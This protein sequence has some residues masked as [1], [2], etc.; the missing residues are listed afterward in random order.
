MEKEAI[1]KA[2][3]VNKIFKTKSGDVWVLKDVNLEINKGDFVVLFGP[4]GCGKSTLLHIC[5]GLESATSGSIEFAGVNMNNADDDQ[6]AEFRKANIGIIYQQ[7]NWI[8][9][10]NVMVNVAFP[11]MLKGYR[12]E[13]AYAKA[14]K[15]IDLVGMEKWV[16]YYPSELSSGQQQ[17]IGLARALVSEP[18]VIIAD[19]PTGN[20]DYKSSLDLISLFKKLA[21]EGT[22]IVMVT[23]NMDNL[24]YSNKI[25]QMFDGQILRTVNPQGYTDKQIHELLTEKLEVSV[26]QKPSQV[27]RTKFQPPKKDG[28]LKKIQHVSVYLVSVMKTLLLITIYMLDS[29]LFKIFKNKLIPHVFLTLYSKFTQRLYTLIEVLDKRQGNTIKFLDLA[30]LS[31]NNLISKKSR[32]LITIGGIAVGIS[33]TVLLISLGYGL[34]NLVITRVASLNELKQVDTIP[35]ISSNI[36]LTDES[37]NSISSFEGVKEVFPLVSIAGIVK[38]NNSQTETVIYAVKTNYL[39]NIEETLIAGEYFENKSEDVTFSDN[40]ILTDEN[41]VLTEEEETTNTKIVD[42]E[43]KDTS[44]VI[45]NSSMLELFALNPED[46][47]GQTVDLEFIVTSNLIDNTTKVRSTAMKYQIVGV[48]D[49]GT[50][51]LAYIPINDVEPLGINKFSQLKVVLDSQDNVQQIRLGI[52]S[53]GFTTTSIVDT[54]IQIE[55]FFSNIRVVFAALGGIALFV[56]SLGMFNTLTVSLLERTR[57]VGLMKAIGMKSKEVRELFLAESVLMGITGG[58]AGIIGG[59]ALGFIL[60]LVISAVSIAR[61]GEYLSLSYMPIGTILGI[62]IL[63]C[64]IGVITG[65]YP[66]RRATRISALN[67]LRYE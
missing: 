47:I 5:M 39:E 62:L 51:P 45:L 50:N 43:G 11:L 23:H 9:S 40:V 55:E 17:K 8:Q 66:A 61:G 63:A 65:L 41:R 67:A 20:L 49:E 38:S 32:S 33:F 6:L 24:N 27:A 13:E 60:S 30:S 3:N 29:L 18:K 34:E 57:E 7:S 15:V 36:F 2:K 25:V 48:T 53:L 37:V 52:E 59:I 64:I 44:E 54:V 4:S 19:E 35:S 46:A 56:A 16:D 14:K 1:L 31:M 42:L 58:V 26:V 28:L 22:T 21:Q 10:A 12:T